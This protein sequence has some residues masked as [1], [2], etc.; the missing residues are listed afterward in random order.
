[1]IHSLSHLLKEKNIFDTQPVT[2][3]KK[4]YYRGYV[5]TI[6]SVLFVASWIEDMWEKFYQLY[7]WQA[8][9]WICGVIINGCICGELDR[10]YVE[11]I[12]SFVFVA[13]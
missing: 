2:S 13:S 7:L 8:K 12:L 3:V 1:M 11:K 5:M 4:K 6:L 9:S 10:G